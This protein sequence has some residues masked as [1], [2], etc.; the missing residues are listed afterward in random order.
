ML[1]SREGIVA[2]KLEFIDFVVPI[3]VIRQKYPGGWDACLKDHANLIGTRV[4]YDE[5]LFRDGAMSPGDIGSLVEE[6]TELG[7]DTFGERD[8]NRY[9]KDVCVVES[10][11]GGP[12]LPCVWLEYDDEQRIAY[13]AGHPA[14]QI[15]GRPDHQA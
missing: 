7:F 10:S 12:T 9:W 11:F 4:W 3:A 14:G 2:I 13:L 8:G 15:I 5:H 1:S 6:W